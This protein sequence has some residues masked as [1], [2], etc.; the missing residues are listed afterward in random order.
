MFED[1]KKE[2]QNCDICKICKDEQV[3]YPDLLQLLSI[4]SRPWEYISMD[5]IEGLPKYK[6]KDTILVVVD[7]YNKYAHFLIL[8]HPCKVAQVAALYLDNIYKLHGTPGSI[9][10]DKDK[11]FLSLFWKE[12]FSLLQT[13][14]LFSSTY[15]PQTNRL[16]ERVNKCLENYTR[17]MTSQKPSDWS[18]WVSLAEFLN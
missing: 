17:H 5:F 16:T 10:S 14:L 9:V 3:E 4:P 7:R 13:K 18:K 8:A 12:L 6:G 11:V 2:V 15:H 1:I